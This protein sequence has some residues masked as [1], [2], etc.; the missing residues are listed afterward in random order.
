MSYS[1]IEKIIELE[2]YQGFTRDFAKFCLEEWERKK[3]SAES[4]EEDVFLEA[5]QLLMDKLAPVEADIEADADT[6]VEPEAELEEEP[7]EDAVVGVETEANHD[8]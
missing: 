6:G 2:N 3:F 4:F 5:V 7:E 8:C 1:P